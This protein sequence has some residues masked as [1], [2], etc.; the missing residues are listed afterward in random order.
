MPYLTETQYA[1]LMDKA[2]RDEKVIKKLKEAA[3]TASAYLIATH[4]KIQ[5]TITDENLV[6]LLDA[7][8][9]EKGI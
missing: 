3:G 4:N 1:H 8:V 6:E 9:L 5:P 7:A 2:V